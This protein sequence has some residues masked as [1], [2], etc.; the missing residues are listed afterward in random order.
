M[1]VVINVCFGGFSLSDEAMELY[2]NKKGI[3]FVKS[4]P[5]KYSTVYANKP[6]VNGFEEFIDPDIE[7]YYSRV[8]DRNDP[9]L[10]EVVQEMG[11]KA[12][13]AHA[14]LKIVDIPDDVDWEIHDYDGNE[15]V[16]EKSRSWS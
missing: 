9:I 5:D 14:D 1:K 11:K 6:Y 12:N 7:F 13:G 3:K 4:S 2:L 8:I 15:T 16:R 10:I